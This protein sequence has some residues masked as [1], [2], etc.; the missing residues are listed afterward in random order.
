MEQAQAPLN[1]VVEIMQANVSKL[2][3]RNTKKRK[4]MDAH[5]VELSKGAQAFGM[6]SRNV[7]RSVVKC[8]GKTSSLQ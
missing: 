8:S 7:R 3:G 2:M 4:E 6:E 1:K 5:R